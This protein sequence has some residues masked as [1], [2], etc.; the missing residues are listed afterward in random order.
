MENNT[1]PKTLE[2]LLPENNPLRA[3]PY[4]NSPDGKNLDAIACMEWLITY[5]TIM[6]SE[7]PC[8]ENKNSI[9]HIAQALQSQSDRTTR[10]KAQK[11][12]GTSKPHEFVP[13]NVPM[14]CG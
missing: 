8:V 5:M 14:D 12:F 1:Q 4:W 11:V 2:N 9:W 10:R 13:L 6:D 7:L 3:F